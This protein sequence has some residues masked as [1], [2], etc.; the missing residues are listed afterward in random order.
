VERS[1][2]RL[3]RAGAIVAALTLVLPLLWIAALVLGILLLVRRRALPGVL[4]LVFGVLV[5]PG[6]GAALYR[7]FVT[8]P[9]RMRAAS[10]EP[11]LRVG[12]CFMVLKLDR[13]AE[14][15]DFVV[16]R[17]PAGALRTDGQCGSPPAQG[18]MCARPI[19]GEAPVTFVKRVVAVGGDRISMRGGRIVRNGEPEPGRP[20]GACEA[21]EGCDFPEEIAVPDGHLFLLGDNRGASEDSRFWG[22]VPEDAVVGRYWFTYWG[23]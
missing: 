22:P 8:Q 21:E 11:S 15:G 4:V 5:L 7:A 14:P 23:G 10:M 1:G 19:A 2:Q 3:V 13:D 20:L 9:F 6:I 18:E 12:E 16:V 17:P